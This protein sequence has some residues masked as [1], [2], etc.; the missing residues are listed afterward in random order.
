MEVYEELNKI[1]LLTRP[2]LIREDRGT[3][4][5]ATKLLMA[6]ALRDDGFPSAASFP[7]L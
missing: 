2:G 4:G 1:Y 5:I 7:R 6:K 3:L